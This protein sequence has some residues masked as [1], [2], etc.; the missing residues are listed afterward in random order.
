[1][2]N[3]KWL[4]EGARDFFRVTGKCDHC[5]E[6]ILHCQWCGTIIGKRFF[7]IICLGWEPKEHPRGYEFYHAHFC[8]R[9]CMESFLAAQT[10]TETISK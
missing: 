4:A 8:K 7:K 9:E 6:E 2:S 3:Q 10:V 5:K 1:M